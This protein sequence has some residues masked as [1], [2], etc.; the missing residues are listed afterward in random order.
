M[1]RRR[2]RH[3]G[4]SIL[5]D[6]AFLVR[7]PAHRLAARVPVH[8]VELL[9]WCSEPRTRAEVATR[10]GP[11]GARLF[12]SLAE[13]GL[14]VAPEVAEH[15]PH[16]FENFASLDVHRRMLADRVRM[17]AYA[18]AIAAVV[19][20]GAAV[21]D[22]GTGTGIL[23]GLAARAGARVVWAVDHSDLVDTAAEVFRAS[24]LSNVHTL[25]ADVSEVALPEPVD[26]VVTETFGAFALAE[27]GLDDIA[28]C[29]A[30]NLAPGG[31]VIPAAV[32]LFLAPVADAALLD[33]AVGPFSPYLGVDLGVLRGTALHR[34]MTATVQPTSLLH[35][36]QPFARLALPS[37]GNARGT[38]SFPDL[39]STDVTGFAGWFTLHLAPG[40]DLDTGPAVPPTHW[41]Q[42]Y[43]PTEPFPVRG[44]L[45]VEVLLEPA[46]EDRR[47]VEISLRWRS[48]AGAGASFHRL[49]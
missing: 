45:Q 19:R 33:E 5:P 38:V 25:R 16:I 12:D 6:G 43:L 1:H 18:R 4:I 29:C 39:P 44:T 11:S 47:G 26:V 49:R 8:A 28:A 36:G 31:V 14:L 32:S 10:Y 24:G 2:V 27:G 37:T 15:T 40:V 42:Q 35:P 13:V 23:A 46:H 22:A 20:P 30:R 41:R 17:D 48:G 21:L 3:L 34:G 7:A 9:A